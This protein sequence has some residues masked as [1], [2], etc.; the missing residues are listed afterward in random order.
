MVS[1]VNLH[2]YNACGGTL[3][4]PATADVLSKVAVARDT[5]APVRVFLGRG[6]ELQE[7]CADLFAPDPATRPEGWPTDDGI[8]YLAG[9]LPLNLR[10][11]STSEP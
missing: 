6:H 2:H 3:G 9:T 7:Q 10:L 11:A 1:D 5:G 8:L 4:R